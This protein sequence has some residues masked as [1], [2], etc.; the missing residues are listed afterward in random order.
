[1]ADP[2]DFEAVEPREPNRP[3][4]KLNVNA[5]GE[6]D[7]QHQG[8]IS[9]RAKGTFTSGLGGGMGLGIG[10]LFGLVIAAIAIYYGVRFYVNRKIDN[11]ETERRERQQVENSGTYALA[12]REVVFVEPLKC[13]VTDVRSD[14][15]GRVIVVLKLSTSNQRTQ[16]RHEGWTGLFKDK[17]NA[18]ALDQHGNSYDVSHYSGG[19][20]PGNSRG[21]LIAADAPL[22]EAIIIAKP[23]PA[24]DE[25]KIV[26]TAEA[27]K[28]G[29]VFRFRVPRELWDKK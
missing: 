7:H 5:S 4:A 15:S 22:V 29:A 18:R 24:C 1:M 19:D 8:E 23:V 10:C 13:E 27:A 12:K 17:D 20:V 16:I 9:H 14:S 26:L 28:P 6:V 3:V 25:I 2:F 11:A 21:G